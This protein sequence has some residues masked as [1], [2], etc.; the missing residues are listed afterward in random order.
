MCVIDP[1]RFR[2]IDA[3]L[4]AETKGKALIEVVSF[5]EVAEGEEKF[6]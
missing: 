4:M 6:E 3:L 2:D 5:K 1:G